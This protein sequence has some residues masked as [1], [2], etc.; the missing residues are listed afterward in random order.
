MYIG[1]SIVAEEQQADSSTL[2]RCHG[3]DDLAAPPSPGLVDLK[4]TIEQEN[5]LA[6]GLSFAKQHIASLKSPEIPA[7]K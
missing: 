3:A 2:L 1:K 4:A 5:D 7:F 6:R